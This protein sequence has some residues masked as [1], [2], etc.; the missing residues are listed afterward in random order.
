[1][2][3]NLLFIVCAA[4]AVASFLLKDLQMIRRLSV[5]AAVAAAAI[6]IA[7]TARALVPGA[8]IGIDLPTSGA[9]TVDGFSAMNAWLVALIYVTASLVSYRYINHERE[10]K[11]LSLKQV[12]VYYACFHAFALAM[13]VALFA[14]NIGVLWTALECTTLATTPL[15]AM[16]RKDAS[17]E[18]AWKYLILCSIGISLGL[19]GFLLMAYAGVSGAGM[20]PVDAMSLRSLLAHAS[21]LPIPVVKWAF[22][23]VFIGLGTKVGFVPMH[24]W[25]PDAHGNTPSPISG[26]LSGV[27]L[28]V[29]F[30]A[31]LRFRH[32]VDA[33]A[34]LSDWTGMLFI[35]FGALSIVLPA[36]ALQHQRHY[37]RMLAY[38]SV[39][40]MGIAAFAA[41]FGP[42]GMPF[43][44]MHMIGH[45]LL[46][47]ALFFGSGEILLHYKSAKIDNVVGCMHRLPV[48]GSLFLIAQLGMLA[49]PPSP[50][51]ASEFL[52]FGNAMR[53]LPWVAVPLI[54]CLSLVMIGLLRHTI[55]I[56]YGGERPEHRE[57]HGLKE[58]FNITH[59]V[60]TTQLLLAAAAGLFFLTNG[61]M[62]FVGRIAASIS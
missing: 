16:Y 40:H 58:A 34:G 35:V 54:L 21:M 4:A 59:A 24:T 30:T 46:K 41:G 25:L 27:L 44:V 31:I 37:K 48:T 9:W 13:F 32:I 55:I 26:M 8:G 50:L 11:I 29:A 10:E 53:T 23:F 61:G 47:S 6:V 49:V 60:V 19:L 18:A 57:T 14:D 33:H 51:M 45:T 17:V 3:L 20:D 38:S 52:I 39:E 22:V 12:R 28:N 42:I 36:L 62:E 7:A 15:V 56:L 1:M 5:A 43:V 2:A